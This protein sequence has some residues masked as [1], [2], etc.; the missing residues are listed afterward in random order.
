MSYLAVA[1]LAAYAVF[2]GRR[3]LTY[4]HYFQQEEYDGRRFLRWL[5]AARAV[6]RRLSL[7]LLAVGLAQLAF[8]A[9]RLPLAAAGIALII[10]AGLLEK[11]PRQTAKKKLVM[12]ARAIRICG[13]AAAL[14]A[15]LALALAALADTR[16][17]C[18]LVAVQAVPF[19]LVLGN[20]ALL[21]AEWRIQRRYR[22]EAKAKLARL[23]PT[24]V[25]ITG[26]YGKTSTKHILGH[27]L[28]G[29]AP[30][31]VTP[32]SVNTEMGIARVVRERLA[33]RHKF[34]VVEMGAYGPGSIARLCRL[35][36]PQLGI[37]TAIGMAHYERFRSVERVAE[38]KFELAE[39]VLGNGGRM[40]LPQSVLGFAPGQKLLAQRPGDF[41]VCGEAGA[42]LAIIGVAQDAAGIAVEL[43][44]QGRPYRLAA[45][46]YGT[47]QATNLALAF[48]AACTLGLRPEDV[49]AALRSTPQIPHRLEVKRRPDWA[50]V[51]DD[52][53]NSNPVGFAA[54]LDVLDVL[55]QPNGRRILVT[56]GMVELGAAHGTEHERIGEL[57]GGLVD[58]LLPVAPQRI[59]PLID[60]FSRRAPKAEIVPC[61]SFQDA[62]S[63]LERHATRADTILLENDLPDLYERKPSL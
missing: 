36:S 11:D 51:I 6:D 15:L 17:L 37:I 7:G 49:V 52:A 59:Q 42:A 28:E 55:R 23:A 30:T 19:A 1:L 63:W 18:W 48:A 22:D 5:A 61:P 38:A 43:E 40:V 35:A 24:I 54:A 32:G 2:A 60:A 8:G 33:Q 46:L 31:L 57:A 10:V 14:L 29:A 58:V 3:L 13:V 27:V 47:Q 53:Y 20:L 39:A 44:W 9:W 12:T 21:P 4:M 56:P 41:V 45:P 62:Q 26:S 25:G 34:F 50:T 16:L